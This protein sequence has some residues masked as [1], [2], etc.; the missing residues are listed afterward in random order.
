M[1]P[2][3]NRGPTLAGGWFRLGGRKPAEA[4]CRDEVLAAL[5][6]LGDRT[7]QKVFT[8]RS[9]YAE[10]LAAGTAYAEST[11]FKTMQRMK[12]PPKRAPYVRLERA[13]KEGFRIVI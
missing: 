9:V 11:V 4:R 7:G 6:R 2:N 1:P 12:D 10:M 5:G 13:G 3:T 8:V